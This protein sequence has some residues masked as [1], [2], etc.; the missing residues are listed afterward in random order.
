M[1]V[2]ALHG[3]LGD[4]D[5]WSGF[6]AATR[7]DGLVL[8][9]P[10][11]PGHGS[12]PEPPP[13]HF[14]AWVAWVCKRLADADGPVH[15]LGYSMGGRLALAAALA[16]R[17]TGRVASLTLLSASPGLA[18]PIGRADRK[19]ADNQRADALVANGLDAFLRQWY[20]TPL[21]TPLRERIGIDAL[22]SRRNRGRA[23]SLAACL[24]TAGAG[25]MPNLRPG[26]ESLA[27]PVL[28][29]AGQRDEKYTALGREVARTAPHGRFASI[30]G[31]G[32]SLLL[33]AP[34]Y[35][36]ELWS[37]F[38]DSNPERAST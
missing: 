2:L 25:V 33:E 5:D 11:L 7:V 8:D 32:H 18:D 36:A 3:F 17:D 4:R 28:A 9:A 20:E 38:V 35:C 16:E 10:D 24:R 15:L 23:S 29:V 12:T 19:A 13:T 30:D 1:R 37:D 14:T 26:L 6:A 34:E 31:A 22:V 27:T 21:F